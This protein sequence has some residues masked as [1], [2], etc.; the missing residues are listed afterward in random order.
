MNGESCVTRHRRA[1]VLIWMDSLLHWGL[2]ADSWNTWGR[3]E[4]TDPSSESSGTWWA[5]H[6]T[7]SPGCVGSPGQPGSRTSQPLEEEEEE[8]AEEEE[9]EGKKISFSCRKVIFTDPQVL[10]EAS[11]LQA[12]SHVKDVNTVNPDIWPKVVKV[13]AFCPGVKVQTCGEKNTLVL[14]LTALATINN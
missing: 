9:E 5:S 10:E 7:C 3:Q 4:S 14:I 2:P 13:S 11:K 8:E 6:R 12:R 1:S